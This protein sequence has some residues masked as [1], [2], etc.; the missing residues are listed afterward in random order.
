M[1]VRHAVADLL[2]EAFADIDIDVLATERQIDEPHRLTALIRGN[3]YA[4]MPEAPVSHRIVRLT[5]IV[6]SSLDDPD[7]GADQLDEALP[8]ILDALD[9]RIPHEEA[10]LALFGT[11]LAYR[12]PLNL[13]A[14]KEA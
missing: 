6:V 11:R 13:I 9:T 3:G 2:R 8:L 1:S 12:I 10:E 7:A 4:R 14:A 5:L